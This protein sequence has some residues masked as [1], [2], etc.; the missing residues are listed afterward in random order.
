[1]HSRLH[2]SGSFR[3]SARV[4]AGRARDCSV[5]VSRF[6]R[7]SSSAQRRHRGT[8]GV[9]GCRPVGR[10]VATRRRCRA[11]VCP[12]LRS[13]DPCPGGA[14][15]IARRSAASAGRLGSRSRRGARICSG[16]GRHR[17]LDRRVR[18]RSR[19]RTRCCGQALG[20][21][22][23]LRRIGRRA[24]RPV[25]F[26]R[27]FGGS[28]PHLC[29]TPYLVHHACRLRAADLQGHVVRANLYEGGETEEQNETEEAEDAWDRGGRRFLRATHVRRSLAVAHLP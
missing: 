27:E 13:R 23:R 12:P 16:N 19:S 26:P 9:N 25:K 20:R 10:S 22:R 21:R 15:F 1:M 18:R 11:D 29:L 28:Q 7:G 3:P 14:R 17:P 6:P 8:A 4:L 2:V 24:P 5:M